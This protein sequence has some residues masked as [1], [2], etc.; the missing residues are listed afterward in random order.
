M[1]I[2]QIGWC[3]RIETLDCRQIFVT[4]DD[5]SGW[6]V[7]LFDQGVSASTLVGGWMSVFSSG[8]K[9]AQNKKGKSRRTS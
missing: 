6:L 1:I 5:R 4:G 8:R 9:P 2:E 3:Q 7:G